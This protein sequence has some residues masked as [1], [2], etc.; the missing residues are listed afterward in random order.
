MKFQSMEYEVNVMEPSQRSL[1]DVKDGL[2]SPAL[3][4]NSPHEKAKNDFSGFKETFRPSIG[5]DEASTNLQSN[6]LSSR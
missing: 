3:S 6:I 4:D 2:D 5:T 1:R